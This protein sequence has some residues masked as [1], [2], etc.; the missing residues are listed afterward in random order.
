MEHLLLSPATRMAHI[1]FTLSCNLSCR[2]CLRH[3]LS[4]RNEQLDMTRLPQILKQLRQRR[5]EAINVNSHGETTLVADWH[6][7]CRALLATGLPVSIITNGIKAFSHEELDTLSRFSL[8]EFSVD[9]ADADTFA[10]LRPPGKLHQVL[11]NMA[12][13]R[14]TAMRNGMPVPAMSWSAVLC[15]TTLAGMQDWLYLGL[16]AGVAR[17]VWCN[18]VKYQGANTADAP[19]HVCELPQA[20]LRKVPALAAELSRV[21]QQH[22]AVFHAVPALMDAVTETLQLPD[23]PP[24]WIRDDDHTVI[25]TG[26]QQ[27]G[28][29]RDCLDPWDSLF[30]VADGTVRHCCVTYDTLGDVRRPLAEMVNNQTVQAYRRG[31]LS[32]RLMPDCRRCSMR[33]WTTRE[34]LARRVRQYIQSRSPSPRLDPALAL[35]GYARAKGEAC[36]SL[37]RINQRERG[38]GGLLVRAP[39][40]TL[41]LTGWAIDGESKQ[42]LTG[43]YIQVGHRLFRGAYGLQRPDVAA[44]FNN[45]DIT[46]CGFRGEIATALPA[47]RHALVLYLLTGNRRVWQVATGVTVE[48]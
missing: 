38:D 45:P 47:G 13:L 20:Q 17:F 41:V 14:A 31:L 32:G 19:R 12:R 29:T 42:T 18:Y 21:A 28:M 16:A 36:Y 3:L 33:G 15:D 10:Y 8:V 23:S 48:V 22:G 6:R 43:L 46:C 37:D 24:R 1:G 34:A 39:S 26:R 5:V 30:I 2:Y 40:G 4:A 9:S 27:P 35:S 7:H 11:E 25:Y 44:F